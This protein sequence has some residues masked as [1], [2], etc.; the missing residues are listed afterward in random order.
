MSDYRLIYFENLEKRLSNKKDFLKAYK[1]NVKSIKST[2]NC[3]FGLSFLCCCCCSVLGHTSLILADFG[4]HWVNSLN[5]YENIPQHKVKKIYID[6]LNILRKI[7]KE[8]TDIDKQNSQLLQKALEA[9]TLDVYNTLKYQQVTYHVSNVMYDQWMYKLFDALYNPEFTRD[10]H[11]ITTE[12][13][14][15][16]FIAL[17]LF[18]PAIV[19]DMKY[20]FSFNAKIAVMI[21][22]VLQKQ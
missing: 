9:K 5:I 8:V 18:Y 11:H 4:R 3:M 19:K 12:E 6:A 17:P 21:K 13:T 10:H 15:K 14:I 20:A 2:A 22:D 16:L 1:S 7:K